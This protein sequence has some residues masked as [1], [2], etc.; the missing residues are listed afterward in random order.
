MITPEKRTRSLIYIIVFLF[1][2]NIVMLA[3]FILN[4]DNRRV[5]RS[6]DNNLVGSFLKTDLQFSET[7]MTAYE[8][9]RKEHFDSAAPLFENI[10]TAKNNF[11]DNIYHDE[12]P[13]SA[14]NTLAAVIGEK[15]VA[16]DKHMLQYFKNIR[17]LCTPAQLP[18]FDSSFKNV[19][20]KITFR[21]L[22]KN[23]SNNH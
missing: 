3:T 14:I 18:R 22:R 21:R 9:L 13:D 1:I 17:A 19:V 5:S 8:K 2:T 20:E 7:Q 10:R 23:S 6:A 11:Y 16:V 15:Q 12:S 4:K